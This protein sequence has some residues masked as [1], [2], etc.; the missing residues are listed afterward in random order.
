[1][2]STNDDLDDGG[3]MEPLRPYLD[4]LASALA[5]AK[6][7]GEVTW[8]AEAVPLRKAAYKVLKRSG[9][10]IPHTDRMKA[11]A[12]R[13]A[14]IYALAD[15]AKVIR[16]E[17]Q[18]AALAVVEY[19]R[20]SARLLFTDAAAAQQ[21]CQPQPDPL[22]LQVLNVIGKAPGVKRG[23]LTTAFK[24]RAKADELDKAL[25]YLE[26]SGLAYKRT[27][28]PQGGGRPAE[29]WYPG[30]TPGGDG[31]EDGEGDAESDGEEVDNPP[32]SP[33]NRLGRV[34]S[35]TAPVRK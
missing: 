17:H 2:R 5:F 26:P 18:R 15:E 16:A 21:H 12:W 14:M 6:H 3:S 28:Q 1:M 13:L 22:W 31:D 10:T 30:P 34:L 19:C 24:N 7:A 20:A 11:Y 23:D 29:C 8:D 32:S 33:P 27:V 25:I 35:P 4:R 9:D